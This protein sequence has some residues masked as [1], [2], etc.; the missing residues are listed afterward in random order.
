MKWVQRLSGGVR[1][2]DNVALSDL[3]SQTYARVEPIY[4]LSRIQFEQTS[5]HSYAYFKINRF[6]ELKST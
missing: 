5:H 2:N 6:N 1:W 3:E 4:N